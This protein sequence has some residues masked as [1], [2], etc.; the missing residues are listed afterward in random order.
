MSWVGVV[1]ANDKRHP[2]Q[3]YSLIDG[4]EKNHDGML[5]LSSSFSP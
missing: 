5:N 1:E 3:V 4:Y 2:L